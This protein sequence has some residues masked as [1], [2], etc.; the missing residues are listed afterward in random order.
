MPMRRV[1]PRMRDAI[2]ASLAE[3]GAR[4]A[5]AREL[6]TVWVGDEGSDLRGADLRAAPREEDHLTRARLVADTLTAAE[7]A[8]LEEC[9]RCRS[10]A[11]LAH[12][13]LAPG[14]ELLSLNEPSPAAE[15]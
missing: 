5:T 15:G 4:P 1:S 2:R 6:L 12:A 9:V 7:R 10:E 11:R 3:R 13:F 14:P 8:H